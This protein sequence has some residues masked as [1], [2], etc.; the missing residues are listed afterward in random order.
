MRSP[1]LPPSFSL[2]AF[3]SID[4]TNEE[5]RRRAASGQA[6]P[7]EVLWARTQTQGRGRRGRAWISP[8]GN[9][10][11]SILVRPD[12]PLADAA[13][14]SFVAGLSVSEAL[15]GLAPGAD[16]R[17]KWPN[18]VLAGGCKISGMLLEAVPPF[19]IVG[20][21]VDV[22][23]A[24]DP[25]LY[26]TTSLRA[27][28]CLAEPAEVLAALVARFG[29][30]RDVWLAQGFAPVRTAWLQ[31]AY[32]LGGPVTVRLDTETAQGVFSGLDETGALLL[33]TG[34]GAPRR[35]LAGDVFFAGS[36]L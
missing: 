4:S 32:G 31:R 8:E 22:V 12:R 11:C 25:A 29:H 15:A 26:P 18:D 7:D 36:H 24:P 27:L 21:G 14:L 5:G 1:D 13:Q 2:V 6:R 23:H 10:H 9:L 30:W 16:I 34:H 33:D 28:G 17:C 3:E 19:V 20:I 35:V